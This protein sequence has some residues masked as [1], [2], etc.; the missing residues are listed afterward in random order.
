MP[1]EDML[2]GTELHV[3]SLYGNVKITI[4]KLSQPE[5]VLRIKEHGIPNMNTHKKG[6]MYLVLQPEFPTKLSDSQISV[7]ELYKKSK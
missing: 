5:S 3:D 4:P 2:L 6:D 1:F 7:L